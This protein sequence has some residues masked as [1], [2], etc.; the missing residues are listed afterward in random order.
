M[1]SVFLY[2]PA[3]YPEHAASVFAAA[4]FMRSAV[5]CGAVVFSRPLFGNLGVG[6]GCSL[7]A[8]LTV[9]CIGGIYLLRFYGGFLRRRSRFGP[10]KGRKW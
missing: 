10:R 7:L 1:Q 8:G 4:D 5:A 2:I 6:G 9:L 3:C